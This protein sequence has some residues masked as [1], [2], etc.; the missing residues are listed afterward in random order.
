MY[1]NTKYPKECFTALKT[2][3]TFSV[4]GAFSPAN[5]KGTDNNAPVSPYKIYH[6][7]FSFFKLS[8]LSKRNGGYTTTAGNIRVEEFPILLENS[9]AALQMEQMTKLRILSDTKLAARGSETAAEKLLKK[10]DSLIYFFKHRSFPQSNPEGAQKAVSAD[11]SELKT[12]ATGT[13]FG[14]GNL[15][16]KTPFL[17]LVEGGTDSGALKKQ[18]SILQGQRDF[19]QEQLPRFKN[20]QVII[21]AIDAA[22]GLLDNAGNLKPGVLDSD[23]ARQGNLLAQPVQPENTIP[24]EIIL[25]AA[26]PKGNRRKMDPNTGLCPTYEIQ[27]KWTIGNLYPVEVMIRN[28]MAPVKTSPTGGQQTE[29]SRMDRST[30]IVNTFKLSSQQ[31]FNC[32]YMMEANMRR[33]ELL[34]A[35]TQF[36]QADQIVRENMENAEHGMVR[37]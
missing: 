36:S 16:G 18:R 35:K 14:F 28:Y 24:E 7:S 32:L 6:P 13:M 1:M 22:F 26:A 23:P 33:F 17:V 27:A 10:M 9:R 20:N 2:N 8:I 12:K 25:H 30:L 29:V 31:W 11:I 34:S 15:R 37:A 3:Q 19:L 21:D 5:G 4:T